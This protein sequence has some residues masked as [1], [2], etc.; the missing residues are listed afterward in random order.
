VAEW[1]IEHDCQLAA[2]E[3]TGS[4]W[5]PV[6]NVLEVLGLEVLIV[7]AHHIKNVPG[8]KTDIKD[9]EWIA[10]L[11]Q[12]GYYNEYIK[13]AKAAMEVDIILT[14]EDVETIDMTLL[15]LRIGSKWYVADMT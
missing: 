2:M 3:S 13:S 9:A 15:L 10:E 6:N 11:L 7:N 5:K 12:H 14:I 1:L 8:R 4:H